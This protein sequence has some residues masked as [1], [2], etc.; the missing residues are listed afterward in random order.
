MLHV[1]YVQFDDHQLTI[2]ARQ[3]KID[4]VIQI[5]YLKFYLLI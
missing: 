4:M 2:T 3:V 5:L 1:H